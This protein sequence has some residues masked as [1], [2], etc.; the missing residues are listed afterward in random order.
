VTAT[1]TLPGAPVLLPTV[2]GRLDP[3]G[4]LRERCRAAIREALPG[5]TRV[6]VVSAATAT[7]GWETEQPYD[8]GR[9]IGRSRVPAPDAATGSLPVGLAVGR[10]LLRSAGWDGALRLQSVDADAAASTCAELAA[11]LDPGPADLLVAVGDGSV[12]RRLQGPGPVHPRA[13]EFD[14]TVLEAWRLGDRDAIS[15]LDPRLATDLLCTG[16]T[17]WQVVAAA[18]GEV[19][20]ARIHYAD[21]PFGVFSLIASWQ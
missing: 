13:E 12:L 18:S 19:S 9:L 10:E 7:A 5:V 21:D 2:G 20:Q 11:A 14:R 1:L 15:A 4:D 17:P 8:V 6:I 16:R 3:A